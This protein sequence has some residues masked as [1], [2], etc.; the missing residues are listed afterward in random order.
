MAQTLLQV[1]SKDIKAWFVDEDDGWSI[2]WLHSKTIDDTLATL[3][4]TLAS[5]TTI[6]WSHP[7]AS[8]DTAILPHLKNPPILEGIDDLANLSYLH[9]YVV[10]LG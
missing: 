3:I 10:L 9:E 7:I 5:G 2:G 4:F 1:Y 6:T 8:L